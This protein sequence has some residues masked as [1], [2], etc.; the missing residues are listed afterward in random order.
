MPMKIAVSVAKVGA[1]KFELLSEPDNKMVSA[2]RSC[3]EFTL[4]LA[5]LDSAKQYANESDKDHLSF[6]SIA[7]T[8]SGRPRKWRFAGEMVDRSASSDFSLKIKRDELTHPTTGFH[9][10]MLLFIW[11]R[12]FNARLACAAGIRASLHYAHQTIEN[13]DSTIARKVY[14]EILEFICTK[15]REEKHMI[16]EDFIR[17]AI[18]TRD[19]ELVRYA[20]NLIKLDNLFFISLD[21]AIDAVVCAV[22]ECGCQSIGD[23]IYDLIHRNHFKHLRFS[24]NLVDKLQA[25][26]RGN[27]CIT[28]CRTMLRS[29]TCIL[30]NEKDSRERRHLSEGC[31]WLDELSSCFLTLLRL[32]VT[33]GDTTITKHLLQMR[34]PFHRSGSEESRIEICYRR[35]ST[36]DR[37]LLAMQC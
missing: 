37:R 14:R 3:G 6:N 15:I 1:L 35:C 26:K 10:R 32:S 2:L 21:S 8:D 11:P 23:L 7:P 5:S 24:V 12:S 17:V 20:L 30:S 29:I 27:A 22:A 34:S 4:H 9:D 25:L 36:L 19:V 16:S 28:D 31:P 13:E 18:L 33:L